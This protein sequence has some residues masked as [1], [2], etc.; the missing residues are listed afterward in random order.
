MRLS[1]GNLTLCAFTIG[2]LLLSIVPAS[3][4]LRILGIFPL[5]G[6][7]HFVMNERLM[8]GLAE[9]GHQ[10]DVYGHFPLNKPPPNYTDYSIASSKLRVAVNNVS[11]ETMTGFSSQVSIKA[12]LD[13]IGFPICELLELPIMQDLIKNPPNNPPY[14]L[15]IVEVG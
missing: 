2:S 12:M 1:I 3:E 7:S 4:S 11:Y 6:K 10:V 13:H 5:N 8:R 15:V 14:D 9:R